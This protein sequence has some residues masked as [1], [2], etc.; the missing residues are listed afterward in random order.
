MI[1]VSFISVL[2]VL[3][4]KLIEILSNTQEQRQQLIFKLNDKLKSEDLKFISNDNLERALSLL[5]FDIK[6]QKS[7]LSNYPIVINTWSFTNATEKAWE[8][9]EFNDNSLMAV[10]AGCTECEKLQ[11]DGTVG[12]LNKKKRNN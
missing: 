1:K 10:V 11:C 3:S 4:L 6:Y 9:L 5:S 7:K 8:N 2:L 12:K